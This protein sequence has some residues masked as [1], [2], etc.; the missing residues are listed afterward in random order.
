M[1][2][3]SPV[4]KM[5]GPQFS[6]QQ[7]HSV[8]VKSWGLSVDPTSRTGY[9]ARKNPRDPTFDHGSCSKTRS[10][11]EKIW[12]FPKI[13]GKN[14]KWMVKIMENPIKI[15]VLGGFPIIFMGDTH[16][17]SWRPFIKNRSNWV[18]RWTFLKP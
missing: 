9:F 11:Q 5:L 7:K 14:P 1:S 12:M 13:G 3:M 2:L 17:V 18:T 4:I 15:H 16:I 8:N 10:H 6:R